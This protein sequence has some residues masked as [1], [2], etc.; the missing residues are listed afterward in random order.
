MIES[1][2]SLLVKQCLEEKKRAFEEL[3]DK[4]QKPIFNVAYRILHNLEDAEDVTQ[5]VFVKA[6]QNL[7]TYNSGYKFFS[8]IYKIAVNE[9]INCR[10][11]RKPVHELDSNIASKDK[12][13]EKIYDDCE[14]EEQVNVALGKIKREYQLVIIL[15]H[16]Q[17]CTYQEMS[18]ILDLPVKTVKSRLFSARQQLKEILTRYI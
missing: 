12:S 6:F 15:K 16:F 18:E 14:I 8:W 7:R 1:D 11:A 5:A 17:D 10:G 3:V 9:A 4:Y 2:D 13:P